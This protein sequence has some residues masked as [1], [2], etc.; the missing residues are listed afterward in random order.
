MALQIAVAVLAVVAIT[1]SVNIW[2]ISEGTKKSRKC[3]IKELNE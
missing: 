1:E 3:L 2:Q